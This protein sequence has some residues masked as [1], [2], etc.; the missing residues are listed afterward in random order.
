MAVAR[1]LD[2]AIFDPLDRAMMASVCAAETLLGRDEM[3]LGYIQAFRAGRL[4]G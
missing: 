2:A 1:G 4:E 3:C